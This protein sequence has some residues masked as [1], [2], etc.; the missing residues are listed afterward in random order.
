MA[1]CVADDFLSDCGHSFIQVIDQVLLCSCGLISHRPHDHCCPTRKTFAR[2]SRLRKIDNHV[3]LLP[4]SHHCTNS[5]CLLTSLIAYCPVAHPSLVQVYRFIPDVL[6]QLSDLGHYGEV[7]VCLIVW[8]GVF[9]TGN[10]FKQV[11]MIQV[12]SGQH[13]GF[14]K[15]N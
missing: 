1:E 7:G 12:M 15:K 14:L 2:R 5:C 13:E 6:A 8:T 11:Q 9:Y 10:E 4:F 3:E